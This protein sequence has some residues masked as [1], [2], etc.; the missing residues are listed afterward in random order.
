MTTAQFLLAL[1]AIFLAA[2]IFGE[3]AERLGQPAVLGEIVGGIVIGVSGLHLVDP[4]DATIH[5]LAELGVILLLFQIGLETDLK[6][7]MSVGG[8]AT[9][10]AFVGVALPLIGGIAFGQFLGLPF[11][12]SVLLGASLTATSVGITARVLSDLGHLQDDESQVI[13]GAAV[14]DDVIGLVLLTLV[15]T[16]AAGG[17]LT[18]AGVTRVTAVAFGFIILAIVAGSKLAPWLVRVVDRVNVARGLFFASVV[19]A[20][21]LAYLAQRVGSA[22]IIGAFAAG[23]VLTRTEKGK[24]IQR[25]VHDV[26]QFFIPIFFVVVGAAID[27]K[28]L[29]PFEVESRRYLLIGLALTLIGIVGKVAAGAAV[30]TKGLRRV[31]VGV[32]MIPRGE[33]GL[34]FAQV[35]L[36]TGL[37]TGGLYSAVALM[38]MITT[39][40]TPPMLRRLLVP[41]TP[42]PR[43]EGTDYAMDAPMDAG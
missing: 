37:L 36:A 33:V 32:G 22:M 10:V 14:V 5:L 25:E 29:N 17:E 26:A 40:I 28:T 3:L 27:L 24:Q 13:L 15:S 9:T 8:S 21:V 42:G 20:F 41:K 43:G 16:L 30:L 35:G 23:L 1:I 39:L 7:L 12:V 31:V 34:I 11:M 6:K 2:K 38:V 19:F 18:A 4:H